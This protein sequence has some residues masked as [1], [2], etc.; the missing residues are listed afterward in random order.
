MNKYLIALIL[1]LFLCFKAFAV[2]VT[3]TSYSGIFYD[4]QDNL[5]LD[6]YSEDDSPK[7][8][9]PLIVVNK[10]IFN[11]N[12][13][14]DTFLISPAIETYLFITPKP[15]RSSIGNFMNNISEPVNFLNSMFQGNFKQAQISI[16]RFL[17]NTVLGFFGIMDVASDAKLAY[18][19]EDFGQTLA[20]YDVPSGPYLVLPIF[21]PSSVRDSVGKVADFFMDPFGHS[22]PRDERD[23]ID[24]TWL[25]HKRAESNGVIKV[26]RKSLNP[27]ETAKSLY[28][29]NRASQI[30]T[31]NREI[32]EQK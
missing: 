20:S 3:P 22:L 19:S 7:I 16:G 4:D 18:S 1:S 32:K 14:I 8:S 9:D 31:N 13:T 2:A 23:V 24:A 30:K 5:T 11:L 6:E 21:G 28:I 25:V 10:L 27:Y 12:L 17:T 26:V 15:V 29:Q